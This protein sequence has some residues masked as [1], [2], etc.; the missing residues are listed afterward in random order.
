M[1]NFTTNYNLQ[2]PFPSE[3]V[4]VNVINQNMDVIDTNLKDI[5][6]KVDSNSN[7]KQVVEN[8]IN[9]KL[10]NPHNITKNTI[11]LGNVEN[12]SSAT[13]RG[14]LTSS[15]VNVNFANKDKEKRETEFS[16]KIYFY[17]TPDTDYDKIGFVMGNSR[18]EIYEGNKGKTTI[19][20]KFPDGKN[21]KCTINVK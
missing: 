16:D 7:L 1:A 3:K 9:D 8:H 20:A 14:E 13:I 17:K 5:A 10:S 21:I 11:G 2:K 12:K 6:D 15:N 19:Y 4:D 18:T